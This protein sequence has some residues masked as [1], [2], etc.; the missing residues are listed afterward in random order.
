MIKSIKRGTKVLEAFDCE[1]DS[2]SM[3]EVSRITSIPKSSVMRIIR[4]LEHLNYLRQCESKK[5]KLGSAVIKLS[6]KAL[7]SNTLRSFARPVMEEIAEKSGETILLN[8]LDEDQSRAICIERIESQH[9][10]RLSIRVGSQTY[11]HAGASA[12]TLLAQL[13]DDKIAKLIEEEGLPKVSKGTITSKEK[14][15]EE[16]KQIRSV[17]YATSVEETDLGAAG[18]SSPISLP[19][20]EMI[21]SLSIAGPI[22]RVKSDFDKNKR[23]VKDAAS[24]V[25]KVME[26]REVR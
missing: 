6:N 8:T 22:N 15:W 19:E 2:L 24:K 25:E 26:E 3:T 11:L 17:V 4:T 9:P 16:I 13:E 21:G 7:G 10:I 18:V 20:E 12:K 5:Y 1:K 14:I 23:L